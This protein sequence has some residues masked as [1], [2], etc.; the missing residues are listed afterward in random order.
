MKEKGRRPAWF[1][2]RTEKKRQA[3]VDVAKKEPNMT[4]EYERQNLK[5]GR[6]KQQEWEETD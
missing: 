3:L 6:V 2:M 1:R 4:N 5:K